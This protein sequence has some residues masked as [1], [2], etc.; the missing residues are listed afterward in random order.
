MFFAIPQSKE[1]PEKL[2]AEFVKYGY[3]LDENY[4]LQEK[5][6]YFEC[7]EKK[8]DTLLIYIPK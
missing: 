2:K 1:I 6:P 7:A 8:H 5:I 4:I 3:N